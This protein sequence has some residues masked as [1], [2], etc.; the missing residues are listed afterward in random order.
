MSAR[1]GLFCVSF[2][3][4]LAAL[5][6]AAPAW[7]ACPAGFP[8]KSPFHLPVEKLVPAAAQ[9]ADHLAKKTLRG[10]AANGVETRQ[11]ADVRLD[12]ERYYRFRIYTPLSAIPPRVRN[13]FIAAGE[14]PTRAEVDSVKRRQVDCLE[15]EVYR[16][17]SEWVERMSKPGKDKRVPDGLVPSSVLRPLRDFARGLLPPEDVDVLFAQD[18]R[19]WGNEQIIA[20][21]IVKSDKVTFDDLVE[22][23]L[24]IP[25]LGRR[26]YGIAAAAMNYFGKPVDRLS[27]AEAAYLAVLPRGPSNYHPVRHADK[28]VERRNWVID[29][30]QAKGFVTE[31]EARSAKAEP[32]KAR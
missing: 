11:L 7:A 10:R 27:L 9:L 3:A 4:A 5:G 24:N 15:I 23:S 29:Q 30:M 28:A 31:A 26:S 16:F 32:L 22:L 25:Y 8:A 18:L 14:A 13:A 21:Y 20:Y 1:R 19:R 6:G 2:A 17:M 12:P